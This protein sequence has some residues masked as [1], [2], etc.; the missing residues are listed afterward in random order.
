[1]GRA[2]SASRS[3]PTRQPACSI[4]WCSVP[5]AG[6]TR[7]IHPRAPVTGRRT[8]IGSSSAVDHGPAAT[9]TV[10]A[11]IGPS[12]VTTPRIASP[13]WTNARTR[14]WCRMSALAAL[15]ASARATV[16]AAGSRRC[17]WSRSQ[18]ATA[19][20]ETAGST[21]CSSAASSSR[22]ATPWAV[23]AVKASCARGTSAPSSATSRWPTGSRSIQ[24]GRAADAATSRY[25]GSVAR[26]IGSSRGSS[27]STNHPWFRP[28]A[29]AA[30]SSRSISVTLAPA[31]DS[32]YA[33]AAP[34]IPPPTIATSGTARR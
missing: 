15:A 4:M 20:G 6:C 32:S 1:M 26:A 28:D 14:T 24:T 23:A 19:S 17:P 12:S 21:S 25:V 18:P 13:S 33:Q 27:G 3:G 30:S 7:T 16:S 22:M 11:W 8:P 9:I 29:P 5:L 2:T 10:S 31:R 34:M